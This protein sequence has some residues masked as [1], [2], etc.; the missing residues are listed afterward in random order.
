VLDWNS[1]ALGFYRSLGAGTMDEWVMHRL[2][3]PALRALAAA[4]P[5]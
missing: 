1:P 3:G 2:A 5:D 4:D